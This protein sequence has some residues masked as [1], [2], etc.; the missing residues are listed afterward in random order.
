VKQNVYWEWKYV[1][2]GKISDTSALLPT[3]VVAGK[4]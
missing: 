3:I 4:K 1:I 2:D